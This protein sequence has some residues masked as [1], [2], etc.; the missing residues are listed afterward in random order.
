MDG[1]LLVTG[2]YDRDYYGTDIRS[3]PVGYRSTEVVESCEGQL[4]IL[5]TRSHV[6]L[7]KV[8]KKNPEKRWLVFFGHF[9]GE[10]FFVILLMENRSIMP[11]TDFKQKNVD[12]FSY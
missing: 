9:S 8:A 6:V 12:F 4:G 1:A 2:G 5:V 11:E 3:L 7:G 10:I